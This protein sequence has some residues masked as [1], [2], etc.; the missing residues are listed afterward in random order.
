MELT[1][2]FK[3]DDC[4]LLANNDYVMR[5]SV[6]ELRWHPKGQPHQTLRLTGTAAEKF[7][8]VL[9]LTRLPLDLIMRCVFQHKNKLYNLLTATEGC[10]ILD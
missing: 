4:T 3:T 10:E 9:D 8:N 7:A 5:S 1:P 2:R 6:I